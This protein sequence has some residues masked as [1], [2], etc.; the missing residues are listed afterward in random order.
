MFLCPLKEYFYQYKFTNRI[1][2]LDY[3]VSIILFSFNILLYNTTCCTIFFSGLTGEQ[4]AERMA[5]M[6][7]AISGSLAHPNIV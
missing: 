6:E 5:L 3:L 1:I 7:S 2:V 4:K